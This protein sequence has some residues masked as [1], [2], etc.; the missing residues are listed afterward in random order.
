MEKVVADLQFQRMANSENSST[1]A[2]LRRERQRNGFSSNL[3]LNVVRIHLCHKQDAIFRMEDSWGKFSF[4]KNFLTRRNRKKRE[5]QVNLSQQHLTSSSTKHNKL[6]KFRV[7]HAGV[8]NQE[9][10]TRRKFNDPKKAVNSLIKQAI[11]EPLSII[12]MLFK[13]LIAL[14][15]N[16]WWKHVEK[17]LTSKKISFR[18]FFT[19]KKLLLTRTRFFPPS[20][21]D[22]LG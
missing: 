3:C 22:N 7:K 17:I 14:H 1:I 16:L 2:V 5:N 12:W 15:Y 10:T 13:I 6:L 20:T 4:F 11:S 19:L 18:A 21:L 9:T 8:E